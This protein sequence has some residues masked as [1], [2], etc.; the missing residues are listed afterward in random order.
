MKLHDFITPEQEAMIDERLGH[1]ATFLQDVLDNPAITE[2]VSGGSELRFQ[3]VTTGAANVHLIAFRPE[4]ATDEPWVAR[5]ITPVE[6]MAE[7]RDVARPEYV[8]GA[9]GDPVT[10]LEVGDTA[11]AAL[12]AL[13][14]KLRQ[15]HPRLLDAAIADRRTAL[16][17]PPQFQSTG[18]VNGPVV[19]AMAG[20]NCESRIISKRI[21]R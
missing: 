12:E 8:P 4:G 3:E 18:L 16:C 1:V 11:E 20:G 17:G 6:F 14:T 13:A 9:D 5:I 2:D 15:A 21:C 19:S 7:H 10:R